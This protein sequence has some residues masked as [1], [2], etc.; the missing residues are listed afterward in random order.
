MLQDFPQPPTATPEVPTYLQFAAQ[1][2][3]EPVYGHGIPDCVAFIPG[4]SFANPQQNWMS[5]S[6]YGGSD[7]FAAPTPVQQIAPPVP[8]PIVPAPQPQIVSA[9]MEVPTAPT[10]LVAPPTQMPTDLVI[11]TSTHMNQAQH[12]INLHPGSAGPF[13]PS[14]WEYHCNYDQQVPFKTAIFRKYVS[15]DMTPTYSSLANSTQLSLQHGSLP[16]P[17]VP[18]RGV[19][20]RRRVHDNH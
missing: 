3:Q 13:R 16:Q 15:F 14:H 12:A 10:H 2:Y 9:P 20:P 18:A 6:T 17:R 4:M 7:F 19:A 8:Q 5:G 11:R 1:P